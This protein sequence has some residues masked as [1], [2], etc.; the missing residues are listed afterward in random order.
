VCLWVGVGVGGKRGVA[1]EVCLCQQPVPS[2]THVRVHTLCV[3][4]CECVRVTDTGKDTDTEEEGGRGGL[5][6]FNHGHHWPNE[7]V[8]VWLRML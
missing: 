8:V 7:V 1:S 5:L 4:V 2:A 3:C 6:L